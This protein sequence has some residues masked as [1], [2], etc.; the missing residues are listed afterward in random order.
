MGT[1]ALQPYW[2]GWTRRVWTDA[3][4]ETIGK[5]L[6]G[7]H[8]VRELSTALAAGRAASAPSYRSGSMRPRWMPLGWWDLNI[9]EFYGPQ[10]GAGN[11][12]SYDPVAEQIDLKALEGAN[13]RVEEL[14]HSLS[15]FTWLAR[16]NGLP[17]LLPLFAAEAHNSFVLASTASALERYRLENARYPT[18][19]SQLV[20]TFIQ[21][22]PHDVIDGKPLRYS[23]VDGVQFKLYSVGLNGVDDH[24]ALPGAPDPKMSYSP[25]SSMEGDWIWPQAPSR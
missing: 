8:P 4:L 7:F 16:T 10:T 25:W 5:L 18:E 11:F 22:V 2:E 19:L 1:K 12:W 20:P 14:R 6:S 13:A 23:C 17:H 15:P 24:G 21:A 3:Q 9:V